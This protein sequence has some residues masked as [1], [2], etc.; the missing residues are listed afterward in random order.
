M[1]IAET[2]FDSSTWTLARNLAGFFVV[3]FWL[4]TAFWVY[5]DARR[6]IDDPWLVAMAVLALAIG[7]SRILLN[8]HFVS[9]VAAGFAVGLA[10]LVAPA[11]WPGFRWL[12][13]RAYLWFARNRLQ[14]T[15]REPK[16]CPRR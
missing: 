7:A 2:F 15:G 10:W 13:D 12:L 5:K 9:D 11:R 3:V 1:P 6:R 16:Y 4:A 14:W 8:V